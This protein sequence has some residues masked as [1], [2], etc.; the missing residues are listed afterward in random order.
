MKHFYGADINAIKAEYL[1]KA[2]PFHKSTRINFDKKLTES[3]FFE[4]LFVDR[5]PKIEDSETKKSND[6]FDSQINDVLRNLNN[7]YAKVDLLHIYGYGGCGKTTFLRNLLRVNYNFDCNK[8][9]I[10]DF[11]GCK[12]IIDAYTETLP[13]MVIANINNLDLLLELLAKINTKRFE[14]SLPQIKAFLNHITFEYGQK[15]IN[16]KEDVDKAMPLLLE[17]N[18]PHLSLYNV[19]VIDFFFTIING[20]KNNFDNTTIPINLVLDNVDSVENIDEE[21]LFLDVIKEFIN[22]CNFFIGHNIDNTKTIKGYPISDL[23]LKIKINCFLTTRIATA[24]KF[25]DIA[26]DMEKIYGWNSIEMPENYYNHCNIIKHRINYY[27][28]QELNNSSERMKELL[29]IREFSDAVFNATKFRKLFNNNIRFII[30]TICVIIQKYANTGLISECCELSNKQDEFGGLAEGINGVIYSLLFN[31]FKENDVYNSKLH[32]TDCQLDGKVSLSR[33]ILTIIREHNW[34]CNLNDI[35]VMLIPLFDENEIC[36]VLF[37]LCKL[38]R[39]VWRR[40][41]IISSPCPQS[42]GDLKELAKE[43]K[44]GNIDNCLECKI[45]LCSSGNAYIEDII[46]HFEFMLSRHKYEYRYDTNI[47]YQPLFSKTSEL[48]ISDTSGLN[49]YLFERKID[50]VYNDVKDCCINCSGFSDKIINFLS[51]EQPISKNE[52]LNNTYFN[53]HPVNSD[54]YPE[55]RQSYESRLIFRHIGYI[56]H[57]RQYLLKKHKEKTTY[58]KD[59]NERLVVRIKMYLDLYYDEKHCYQNIAQTE[60]AK[61]L[62]SRIEEIEKSQYTN[63]T[64]KIEAKRIT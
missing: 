3:I 12:K 28:R 16:V 27:E 4:N 10:I 39:D 9:H 46:P 31:Y 57:Y 54:G 29:Q 48:I 50:W 61:I 47:N 30:D 44:R 33:I 1:L 51:T 25:K 58:C 20:L 21:Y 45:N 26:P 41:I 34:S 43:F 17:G 38:N 60:A 56:E 22:D 18:N 24:H 64:T 32:L 36:E 55:M 6:I 13:K 2:T 62:S 14:K 11:E 8:D 37:S 23:I 52:Y 53:Y 49:Q 5:M 63:F 15:R 59:I 42:A 7:P 19:V 35:F 40:L